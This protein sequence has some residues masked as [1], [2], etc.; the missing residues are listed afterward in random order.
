MNSNGSLL[1]G[2][3]GAGQNLTDFNWIYMQTPVEIAGES[4]GVRP[5]FENAESL[6]R[7]RTRTIFNRAADDRVL[8]ATFRRK[9]KS[10]LRHKRF[11]PSNRKGKPKILI[12]L[13]YICS[14]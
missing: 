12:R 1:L 6:L 10:R 5:G 2:K 14:Q 4:H 9:S 13:T 11:T 7:N 3:I 8:S